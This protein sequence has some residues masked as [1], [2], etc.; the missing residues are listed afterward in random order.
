MGPLGE[1]YQRLVQVLELVRVEELLP[2]SRGWRG[3]PPK[4]EQRPKALSRLQRQGAM[5]LEE[6][7]KELP[8]ACD[9][10]VKSTRKGYLE[11]WTG[12]KLH[13]DAIDGGIPVSCLL[14][15]AS[16]HDSQAAIPL[17]TLTSRRVDSLYDLKE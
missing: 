15:S 8:K 16:V 13:I 9:T 7:L 14:T 5:T 3:R 4:G 10:G 1:R 11:R 2:Y 6:M 12:Y 17:A